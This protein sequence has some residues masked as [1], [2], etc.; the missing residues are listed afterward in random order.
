MYRTGDRVRRLADGALEYLGRVDGQVKIRGFRVEPGEV[1]AALL[2]HPRVRE[3]AVVAQEIGDT[4]RLVAYLVGDPGD[5]PA[6]FLRDSLPDH[7]V[8][9]AFVTLPA[10]P[11]TP[12]GK[13]D[14]RALPEPTWH[15]DEHVPRA[16]AWRRRS[17]RSGPTSSASTG[18][19]R[20]TTSSPP[21]A[22]PS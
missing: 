7:L 20:G 3:A 17:R 11:T 19:A 22:I 12:N 1:E 5:D 4:H 14:R 18:S 21:A 13:L 16:P 6:A 10:L 15:A 2:R 8:P 9:S